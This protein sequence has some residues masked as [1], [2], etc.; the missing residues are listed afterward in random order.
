MVFSFG[1]YIRHC[2][3]L[4]QSSVDTPICDEYY[5]LY[6]DVAESLVTKLNSLIESWHQEVSGSLYHDHGC[7]L[8]LVD[9]YPIF[10]SVDLKKKFPLRGP[11]IKNWRERKPEGFKE[12]H[13]DGPVGDYQF[14]DE[15]HPT[16]RFYEELAEHFKKALPAA[17]GPLPLPAA[18]TL[19]EPPTQWPIFR[20][21][22]SGT[23]Q[24]WYPWHVPPASALRQER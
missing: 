6:R 20:W 3:N 5:K 14:H 15:L 1:A 4:T 2:Q 16:T 13:E 24:M 11:Y 23:F 8:I 17:Y 18:K 7:R 22:T 19:E 12:E 9:P 10:N 21:P